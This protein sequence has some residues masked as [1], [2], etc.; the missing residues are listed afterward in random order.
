MVRKLYLLQHF[1]AVP[2]ST[3]FVPFRLLT[4]PLSTFPFHDT[5]HMGVS[6]LLCCLKLVGA[7][8]QIGG[9]LQVGVARGVAVSG[10]VGVAMGT[11]VGVVVG[12][13]VGFVLLL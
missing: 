8:S 13:A 6:I 1:C 7:S 3:P 4:P 5:K 12:V 9:V 2:S 10:A 11:A